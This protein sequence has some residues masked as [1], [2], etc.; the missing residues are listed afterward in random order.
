MAEL[1][2]YTTQ[3]P[4]TPDS[5]SP[6]GQRELGTGFQSSINTYA[7]AMRWLAATTAPGT[8]PVG[9]LWSVA[10]AN[11]NTGTL[12]AS[13]SKTAA[14]VVT[15]TWNRINFATPIALVA[16][17]WYVVSV[18]LPANYAFRNPN[19]FPISNGT[20]TTADGTN[21]GG[22]G[23]FSNGVAAGNLPQVQAGST[24]FDFLVDI[25][26]DPAPGGGSAAP[27]PFVISGA[28]L[29]RD[30]GRV[31]LIRSSLVDPTV[32]AV[33]TPAPVVVTGRLWTP[34][35]AAVRPLVLRAPLL[36]DP[37][38]TAPVVVSAP[39]VK[40]RPVPP[41]FLR[42][43]LVDVAVPTVATPAPIV[44]TG[45]PRRGAVAAVIALRAPLPA[46]DVPPVDCTVR[47]P[48]TGTVSRA[49]TGTV[50]RPYTGV[51]AR[52]GCD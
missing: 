34:A 25:I 16:G 22:N 41:V 52:P 20:L 39:A 42:G 13:Q 2:V 33:A 49:A 35:T 10:A 38:G 28:S 26:T 7:V 15:G 17:N 24:G 5:N 19:P 6:S 21:S 48:F 36:P 40:V 11:S 46:G 3:T 12:L 43:G 1:S 47:R 50:G 9:E 51:V 44:V 14:S 45:A 4:D 29:R 31:V 18:W 8:D 30:P 32:P 37:A 23:R 27:A